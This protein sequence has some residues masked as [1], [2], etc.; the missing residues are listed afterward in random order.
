M[1]DII[2]G[3]SDDYFYTVGGT[4]DIEPVVP[5]GNHITNI[6]IKFSGPHRALV[7]VDIRLFSATE[8]PSYHVVV[9]LIDLKNPKHARAFE[10]H[11][12]EGKLIANPLQG[13]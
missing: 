10:K 8:T 4:W 5:N 1:L 3:E 9:G 13:S 12:L 7:I 2:L 11:R 6:R